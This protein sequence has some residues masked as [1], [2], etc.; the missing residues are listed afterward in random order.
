MTTLLF[1]IVTNHLLRFVSACLYY[2][3]VLLTT[4]FLQYD[5]HCGRPLCDVMVLYNILTHNCLH[6]GID[7]V[8]NITCEEAELTPDE[9]LKILWTAAAELPGI[10]N[11][12][13]TF[14]K[15]VAVEGVL[16][17]VAI[18]NSR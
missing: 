4:T 15:S 3:V 16:G 7:L 9:Y 11:L 13:G 17:A 12:K 6:S 1:V 18:V 5:P 10:C 14:T 2:G 8:S